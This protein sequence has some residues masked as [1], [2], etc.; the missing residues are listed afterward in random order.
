MKFL[1]ALKNHWTKKD[2]NETRLRQLTMVIK[3]WKGIII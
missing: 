1:N 3:P 2:R